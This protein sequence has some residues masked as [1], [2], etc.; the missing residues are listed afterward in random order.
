SGEGKEKIEKKYGRIS[1]SSVGA[2]VRK[3]VVLQQ[4]GAELFFGEPSFD[5]KDL[6]RVNEEGRGIVNILRVTD[7][8][9]SPKLFSTFML[10]L[11]AEVYHKFPEEGDMA[12]PKLVMFIDEA[13]L[14]FEEASDVL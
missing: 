2:M 11:L 3:L 1:S 7:I 6:L 8:Q 4:Q 12:K 14:V 9:R 5:V 13:H 10:Q